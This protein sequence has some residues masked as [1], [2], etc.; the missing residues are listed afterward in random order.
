MQPKQRNILNAERFVCFANKLIATAIR[1]I[2]FAFR[3]ISTAFRFIQSA[4]RNINYSIGNIASVNRII[5]TA[6]QTEKKGLQ[7]TSVW[8]K[9]G[10]SA[11]FNSCT[12]IEI[13]Y[14][15]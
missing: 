11:K 1:F 14:I 12:S 8:Q 5:I 6:K 9:R 7:I 4:E 15:S 13:L 3:I 10:E 2:L